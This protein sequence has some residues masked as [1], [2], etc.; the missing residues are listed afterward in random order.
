MVS[1]WKGSSFIP[2]FLCMQHHKCARRVNWVHCVLLWCFISCLDSHSDGT[3]SLQR[4]HWWT[5]EIHFSKP[6]PMTEQTH[7]HPELPEGEYIFLGDFN[8]LWSITLQYTQCTYSLKEFMTKVALL[9]PL[10]Y[11][12]Q[13]CYC[14]IYTIACFLILI[15]C[16][17]WNGSLSPS[18]GTNYGAQKLISSSAI[19]PRHAHTHTHT[20]TH[21]PL[22]V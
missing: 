4:I 12:A 11:L 19:K 15:M 2:S 14:N 22:C 21:T 1:Q 17:F 5:S 16:V 7:L 6:I 18:S 20:H 13:R 8:F 3:H 10:S 9:R